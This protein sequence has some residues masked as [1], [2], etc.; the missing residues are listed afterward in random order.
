MAKR[1]QKYSERNARILE[2]I[3]DLVRE[4]IKN[5]R[6]DRK[7]LAGKVVNKKTGKPISFPALSLI[8]NGKKAFDK[9]VYESLVENLT[10]SGVIVNLIEEYRSSPTP[11]AT[12]RIN[13]MFNCIFA[14]SSKSYTSDHFSLKVTKT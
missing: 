10:V 14:P 13:T 6:I 8:E 9:S 4:A 5:D 1:P 7:R 11:V 12:Q 2:K 3:G